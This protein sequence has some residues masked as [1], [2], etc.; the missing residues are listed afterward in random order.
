MRMLPSPL[1]QQLTTHRFSTRLLHAGAKTSDILSSYIDCIRCLSIVEPSQL[2][3]SSVSIPIR[4]YLKYYS[5]SLT[6]TL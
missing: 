5:L 3:L 6:L 2:V 1:S 4:R